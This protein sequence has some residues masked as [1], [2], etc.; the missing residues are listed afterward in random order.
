MK[1]QVLIEMDDGASGIRAV[2]V[3]DSAMRAYNEELVRAEPSAEIDFEVLGIVRT[4]RENRVEPKHD[5]SCAEWCN[6][7]SECGDGIMYGSRCRD[8][9]QGADRE[10]GSNQ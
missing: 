2:N 10:N 7:C 9:Y 4:N 8:H 3:L 5:A 6:H 1:V